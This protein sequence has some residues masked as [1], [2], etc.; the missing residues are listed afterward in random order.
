MW[1]KSQQLKSDQ[2]GRPPGE[3]ALAILA[4]LD[5]KLKEIE[6]P[7][8]SYKPWQHK[9]GVTGVDLL[10][11]FL[12]SP[13]VP[14][15][16]VCGPPGSGKSTY[17]AELADPEDLVLDVDVMAARICGCA[18]YCA[19]Q[20]GRMEALRARNL[21]LYRLRKPIRQKKVWLIVTAGTQ[22]QRDFWSARY[23]PLT[24]MQ[25]GKDVC[26]AR[27]RS[28]TRRPAAVMNSSIQAVHKWQ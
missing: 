25:T 24:I 9:N 26:I 8:E 3:V 15:E 6:L 7:Y 4:A 17:V 23:G 28:D 1:C 2:Q 10:P 14:V 21:I 16:V 18:I 11:K 22:L 5:S 12:P 27:I 19:D 13:A 20:S